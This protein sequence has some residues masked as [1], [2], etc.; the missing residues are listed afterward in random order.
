MKKFESSGG[1]DKFFV[2]GKMGSMKR[3]GNF[4][5]LLFENWFLGSRK[6]LLESKAKVVLVQSCWFEKG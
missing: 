6:K 3:L 5:S 4:L 2:F 1:L